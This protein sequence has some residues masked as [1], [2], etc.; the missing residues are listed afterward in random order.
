M[1]KRKNWDRIKIKGMTFYGYHGV[2][3]EEKALGQLFH[4][5]LELMLDL[6][7][8]GASDRLED[9]IDYAAVFAVV[10]AVV[11]GPP[12]GTI[13]AVATAVARRVLADFSRIGRVRVGVTKPQAPIPGILQGV[14]VEILRSQAWFRREK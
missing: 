2:R 14:T 3:P 7:A 5:D 6:Q 13:E 12:F 9:T 4:V 11:E 1:L 10:K 8:A